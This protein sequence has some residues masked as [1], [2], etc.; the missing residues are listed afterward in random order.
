M[1]MDAGRLRE[2][3]AI[4]RPVSTDDDTGGQDITYRTWRTVRAQVTP[5]G[6]GERIEAMALHGIRPYRIVIRALD[7]ETTDRV[8]WKGKTLEIK[9]AGY[10]DRQQR[11]TEIVAEEIAGR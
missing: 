10:L 9:A 6:G 8:R 7:V 5:T 11:W 2:T 4:E 3:L 1:H